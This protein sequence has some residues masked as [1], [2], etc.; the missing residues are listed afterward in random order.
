VEHV[1]GF[2]AIKNRERG[3]LSPDFEHALYQVC[4]VSPLPDAIQP[5]GDGFLRS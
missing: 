3:A 5:F 2:S 4:P 1:L